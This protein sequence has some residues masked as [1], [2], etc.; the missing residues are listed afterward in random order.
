MYF[1]LK[2]NNYFSAK[3]SSLKVLFCHFLCSQVSAMYHIFDTFF[4]TLQVDRSLA[5]GRKRWIGKW[6]EVLATGNSLW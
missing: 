5:A 4:F 6:S 2:V 3:F 1:S